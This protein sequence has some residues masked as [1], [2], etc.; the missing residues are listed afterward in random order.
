MDDD[1]FIVVSVS[2][3]TVRPDVGRDGGRSRRSEPTSYSVLDTVDA[4]R[5]VGQFY[6]HG[7]GGS[8]KRLRKKAHEFCD[9]LNAEEREYEQG[10]A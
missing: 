8:S 6:M 4:Y 3:A 2:G 9:R 10:F 7:M 5:E 1:R